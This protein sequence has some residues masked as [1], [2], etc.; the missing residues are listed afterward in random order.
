MLAPH[1]RARRLPIIAGASLIAAAT[2]AHAAGEKVIGYQYDEIGNLQKVMDVT[3]DAANC[4]RIGSACPSGNACCTGACSNLSA[5]T[6]NCLACGTKCSAPSNGYPTCGAT[7]CSFECATSYTKCSTECVDTSTSEEHCGGC[8]IPCALGN[9][10]CLGSCTNVSSDPK[11]C[12]ACGTQCPDPSHGYGTCM[13]STCGF[14]CNSGYADCNNTRA[15][16]CEAYLVTDAKNCG[17]CG[18]QCTGIPNGYGYCAS[19]TCRTACNYGYHKCFR[20]CYP[21]GVLCP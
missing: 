15:D 16:G 21:N 18:R 12:S 3:S 8:G 5:D 2:V 11:N 4:G 19:S 1:V 10:C 13:T 9:T 17:A 14:A 7:G 6:N 20:E